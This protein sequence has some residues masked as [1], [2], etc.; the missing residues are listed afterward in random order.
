MATGLM[1][2]ARV[3]PL[4]MGMTVQGQKVFFACTVTLGLFL[5]PVAIAKWHMGEEK[6]ASNTTHRD[7]RRSVA[8]T[9]VSTTASTQSNGPLSIKSISAVQGGNGRSKNWIWVQ[10]EVASQS[11]VAL[12]IMNHPVTTKIDG[13]ECRHQLE[14]STL[15]LI[16]DKG[17]SSRKL[18]FFIALKEGQRPK[19]LEVKIQYQLASMEW[20]H[21]GRY[22]AVQSDYKFNRL[23]EIMEVTKTAKIQLAHDQVA[24]R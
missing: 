16:I 21:R 7:V 11:V 3:S 2:R 8:S 24:H 1:N 10:M 20:D 14:Y 23:G 5:L 22:I 12:A 6:V 18:G 15:D 13:V 9:P 17:R 4:W 19:S